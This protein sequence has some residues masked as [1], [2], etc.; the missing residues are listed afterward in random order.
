MG[1]SGTLDVDTR[2][3][4][5]NIA[6]FLLTIG[7]GDSAVQQTLAVPVGCTQVWFFDPQPDG[8]PS[9]DPVT[10]TEVEQ[11]FERGTML[12][13]QA[14]TRVYVLFNDGQQP[15]WATYPDQFKDG[16]PETDPSIIPP[17]KLLQPKRGFGLV[18]RSHT[19]V[20]QRLGWATNPETSFTG[21]LQG[22]ATVDN[23][24]MY[25]Q[26]QDHIIYGLFNKGASWK[27]ITPP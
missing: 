2:P 16:Q 1:R 12:W 18:W 24:V 26:A 20:R 3:E 6:Q 23:G 5:G 17:S 4:D 22:D 19:L 11:P 13:V 15:A 9:A 21:T 10:S 14:Q 27:L 8:C 25:I 7:E